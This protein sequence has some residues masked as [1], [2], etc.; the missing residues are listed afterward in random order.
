MPGSKF[1]NAEI[2]QKSGKINMQSSIEELS[3]HNLTRK[4]QDIDKKSTQTI[5]A[6]TVQESGMTCI[7]KQDKFS[8]N[9]IKEIHYGLEVN[10]TEASKNSRNTEISSHR[11][12]VSPSSNTL[13]DRI[14]E[15]YFSQLNDKHFDNVKNQKSVSSID[16]INA[17]FFGFHN[18]LLASTQISGNLLSFYALRSDSKETLKNLHNC[19]CG[20][21]YC[22][23]DSDC[24]SEETEE[25]SNNARYLLTGICVAL[26]GIAVLLNL[27]LDSLN[28]KKGTVTFPWSHAFATVKF[29]TKKEQALLIPLTLFSSM[30]RSFYM[31]AFTKAYIGCAWSTS[32]IGL[33]TVFYGLSAAVSS[34]L[35]GYVIKFV[36]RK[37]VF[38]V[39][40][41]VSTINL[42]FMLLWKPRPQQSL[43]F[44]LAGSLWG[45]NA[46]VISSQLKG[47]GPFPSCLQRFHLWDS[48]FC[49]SGD[50]VTYGNAIL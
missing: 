7:F 11:D 30:Y 12:N 41:V 32:H 16:N 47:H 13:N 33:V 26:A 44:Y 4:M 39:C 24:F 28:E 48:S 27:F 50:V 8:T 22:N 6:N 5:I 40:Q 14:D 1:T 2:P 31:A 42:V 37:C 3:A 15:R 46:G 20:A 10:R 45:I 34:L 38:V 35:A 18:L 23:T 25:V 19:S 9:G 17:I 21:D 29:N 43:L 49:S 36:G